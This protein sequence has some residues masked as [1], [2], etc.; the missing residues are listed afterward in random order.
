MGNLIQV[1]NKTFLIA[2]L[3]CMC[4]TYNYAQNKNEYLSKHASCKHPGSRGRIF[5]R[6]P[7]VS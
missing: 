3:V 1:V 4:F 7:E 6:Y 5:S 2:V